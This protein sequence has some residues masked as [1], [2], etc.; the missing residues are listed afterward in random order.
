MKA[1][2]FIVGFVVWAPTILLGMLSPAPR[3][4]GTGFIGALSP[5]VFLGISAVAREAKGGSLIALMWIVALAPLLMVAGMLLTSLIRHAVFSSAYSPTDEL[6][7]SALASLVWV[8][9]GAIQYAA[10][11]SD[12]GKQRSDQV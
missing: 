8:A 12:N 7:S 11:S 6:W 9:I 1:F 3:F 4:T 2:V 10:S 5:L